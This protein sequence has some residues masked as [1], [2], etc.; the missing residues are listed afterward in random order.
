MGEF[1]NLR[2]FDL[3]LEPP[4][5]KIDTIERYKGLM[6]MI[7]EFSTELAGEYPQDLIWVVWEIPKDE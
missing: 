5:I 2:R 4:D 7:M 1:I 6:A 3:Q